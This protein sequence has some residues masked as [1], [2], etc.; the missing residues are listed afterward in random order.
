[1]EKQ[2]VVEPI[3][4]EIALRAQQEAPA[5]LKRAE[6]LVIFNQGQY[7]KAN[8]DLKLLKIKIR[9][10]DSKRKEITKPLDQAKNAVMDL[11][12]T[13][14]E[15]LA[16]AESIVKRAM[17]TYAEEQE[18]LRREEQRKIDAKARVEEDRKR[19][20]LAARAEKWAAKGNEAKAEELQE[21]AEE[22]HVE[23]PVIAP[24]AEKPKGVSYRDKW[25]VDKIVDA[26]KVP[27][28]Y[29]EINIS[30]LNT[31]AQATKGLAKIAGVTFKC[32]KILSSRG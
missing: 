10:F 32:E 19:K 6:A 26:E 21:Q 28:E 14:L 29:L 7:E 16:K 4:T 8:S 2:I 15:I 24:I 18:R 17:I 27:R 31:I 1:M 5:I 30:A 22:V 11:F 20:E 3:S 9:E 23:T 12:R 13:P 25:S